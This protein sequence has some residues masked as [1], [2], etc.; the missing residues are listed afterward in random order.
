M[1]LGDRQPS[2]QGSR[3]AHQHEVEHDLTRPKITTT[4]CRRWLSLPSLQAWGPTSHFT[5]HDP[6]FHVSWLG[7]RAVQ[8]EQHNVQTSTLRHTGTQ[9]P[10]YLYCEPLILQ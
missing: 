8:A 6:F 3:D 4:S 5:F 9:V 2:A 10:R 7:T 1:V